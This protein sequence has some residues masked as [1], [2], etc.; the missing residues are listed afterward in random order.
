MAA[1]L[2]HARQAER[3]FLLSVSHEL[4]TPLTA[5]RGYA[6]ALQ[7]AAVAPDE[8][9]RVIAREA[10]RLERL[11]QD[12]LD[13][14]RLDLARTEGPVGRGFEV[15]REPFD[16][17][18]VA[19]DAVRR[20]EPQA[21]GF[22]VALAAD[23]AEPATGVGDAGRTLQAV[24]NLV[25]NALRCTPAGGRVLVA[26]R[27]GEV[28]VADT[29]PGIAP[30]DRD[31]AFERFYLH[32]R[33]SAERP[34]GSGLGLAIVKELAEAMGGSVSVRGEPGAGSTFTIRL[35]VT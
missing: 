29:G 24:S 15:R 23:A 31:R 9:G 4:K 1:R 20:H 21:R 16:L 32:G 11:V 28:S 7:E 13:L 33:Y 6:E 8:G 34:V 25:E 3:R 26:A 19:R 18:E 30:Q 22:G 27:A 5:V 14:A 12:L 35:P 2:E 17:A 10:E